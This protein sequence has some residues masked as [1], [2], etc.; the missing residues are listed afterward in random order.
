[1]YIA[2]YMLNNGNMQNLTNFQKQ[3]ILIMKEERDKYFANN[4]ALFTTGG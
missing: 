1:M 2:G 3:A 4:K